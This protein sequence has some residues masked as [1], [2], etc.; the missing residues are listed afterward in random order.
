MSALDHLETPVVQYARAGETLTIH[1]EPC[2][3]WSNCGAPAPS[4][5]CIPCHQPLA[6]QGQLEMHIE[7]GTHRLAARCAVH[8]WEAV[9]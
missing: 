5:F 3:L 8:G 2:M 1:G 9:R 4:L 6:N 7:S